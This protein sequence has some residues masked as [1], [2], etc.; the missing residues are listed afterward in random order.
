M[1]HTS[2][3]ILYTNPAGRQKQWQSN[4]KDSSVIAFDW[5]ITKLYLHLG[6]CSHMGI[7]YHGSLSE[8]YS[9]FSL[10]IL[11]CDWHGLW[12]NTFN[13]L[14]QTATVNCVKCCHCSHRTHFFSSNND[15][16]VAIGSADVW[17]KSKT[18]VLVQLHDSRHPSR[19]ILVSTKSVVGSLAWLVGEYPEGIRLATKGSTT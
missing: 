17:L 19:P 14:I 7:R 3:Q 15:G 2:R 8:Y 4:T 13:V 12:F 10:G 9:H 16:S 11:Y 18:H 1:P 6:W 5:T